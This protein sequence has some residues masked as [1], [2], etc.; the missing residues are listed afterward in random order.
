MAILYESFVIVARI[1]GIHVSSKE[2]SS[3]EN[4]LWI[5]TAMKKQV[6]KIAT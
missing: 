1:F 3:I 5:Q 6:K 4:V 2:L